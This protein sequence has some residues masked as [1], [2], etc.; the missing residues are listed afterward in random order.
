MQY[1]EFT[2]EEQEIL[3]D[4]LQHALAEIDIEVYQTDT[5]DSKQTLEH[6]REVLEH[7]L[8]ELSPVPMRAAA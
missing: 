2:T 6:R 4:V 7:V 8:A 1:L 5:R 3:R